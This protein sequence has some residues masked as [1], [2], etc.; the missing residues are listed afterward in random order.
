M[1][2]Y[3]QWNLTIAST[4]GLAGMIIGTLI[5]SGLDWSALLGAFIA[6]LLIFMGNY[7]NVKSKKDRT[8]EVDERTIN[9]MRKYYAIIANVFLG[10][11]FLLLAAVTFMGY[12]QVSI[13]YLWIFVILY[14]FV[15][16][17]G[18]LIVLRR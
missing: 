13:L 18:A 9:N 1:K 17:I 15:S 12:D 7:I 16:G 6:F 10:A 8:P 14:M 3:A 4:I 5:F 2:K 11:L